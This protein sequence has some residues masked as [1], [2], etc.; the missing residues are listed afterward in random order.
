M[1]T[2]G[3]NI[4]LFAIFIF[5]GIFLFH[6]YSSRLKKKRG[7]L[8]LSLLCIYSFFFSSPYFTIFYASMR[9]TV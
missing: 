2:T 6:L 8:D 5:L 1:M 9:L 4:V 7:G 3:G